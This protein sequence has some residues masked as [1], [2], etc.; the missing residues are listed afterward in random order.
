MGDR[1]VDVL[2]L[3]ARLTALGYWNGASDG[4]FGELTRQAV[5]A[6]QKAAGLSRDG[7]VG[8]KTRAALTAGVRPTARTASGHLVEID[9]K[10]QLLLVVSDGHVD[11]IFNTST[12]GGY[13]YIDQGYEYLAV[14]PTGSYRISWQTD[15]WAHSTLGWLWRPKYFNGGIAIHGYAEVP[16]YPAS[17]GCVRLSLEAVNSVWS[18]GSM[19]IGTRVLVY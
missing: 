11:T 3:Q 5:V 14:T 1:G 19:P 17:H 16:S 18:S 7:V 10:R 2:A 4:V 6:I 13:R 12:G 9:L 15:G 8:P